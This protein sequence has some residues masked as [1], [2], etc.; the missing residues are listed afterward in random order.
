LLTAIA[1]PVPTTEDGAPIPK[2][3]KYPAEFDDT[4]FIVGKTIDYI[5]SANG[6]FVAH[7]SILRPH[8]PFVAPEPYN[9]MYDPAKVPKFKRLATPKDEA[10][11]HPWLAYQLSRKVYRA[12]G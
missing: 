10:H 12:T 8:P 2:P 11:Q 4:A 6:P 5:K 3:L 9:S 1:R 7:L